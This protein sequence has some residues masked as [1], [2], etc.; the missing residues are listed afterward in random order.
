MENRVN[1]NASQKPFQRTRMPFFPRLSFAMVRQPNA[2]FET[3]VLA[4]KPSS[5]PFPRQCHLHCMWVPRALIV[6]LVTLS[7]GCAAAT[8]STS[9]PSAR[10][11]VRE[12]LVVHSDFHVPKR[13]RLI[14]EL[15]QRR[16][17]IAD[18]LSLPISDEPINVYLFENEK[19]YR[20]YLDHWHPSFPDRRAF[21]VKTDTELIV[22]AYWGERVAEDLRHE[23]TH[24]YL[25]STVP[26]LPL[27]MD[28]G[29]A[30]YFEVPRGKKG[31]NAAHVYLLANR[32]RK[33]AWEPNL[34]RLESKDLAEDLTQVDYAESWLWVHFL[35]NHSE[36]T[37][38][39]LNGQ[40]EILRS[41]AAADPM[42]P[43]IRG[44]VTGFEERLIEHLRDLARNL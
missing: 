22:Y 33:Q 14:D 20:S 40:L 11:I 3:I 35:I 6:M 12:Q 9:L 10:Q 28:E 8:N 24:G 13:H 32:F 44:V 21:F 2:C 4:F 30:E 26:N 31:L 27:W 29:L 37:R 36:A 7:I 39:L 41:N 5:H 16:D 17:D 1:T 18:L 19:R 43:K 23:V 25:H 38:N 34:A 42:E 15:C